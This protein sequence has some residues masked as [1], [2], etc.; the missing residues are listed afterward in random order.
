MPSPYLC[1]E[2]P[3]VHG[4]TR[5]WFDIVGELGVHR[6]VDEATTAVVAHQLLTTLAVIAGSSAV[7]RDGWH[8]LTARDRASIL[9]KMESCAVEAAQHL[10]GLVT[11]RPEPLV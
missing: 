5:R 4:D 2:M 11:G 8:Q 1:R 10:R 9:N 3:Q 7:L 6:G